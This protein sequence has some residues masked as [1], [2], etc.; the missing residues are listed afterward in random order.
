MNIT[1]ACPLPSPTT[2]FFLVWERE[3][4]VQFSTDSDG[5]DERTTF[6]HKSFTKS[7]ANK[8]YPSG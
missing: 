6:V 1:F 8:K 5:M 2:M 4:L 3:H 7:A